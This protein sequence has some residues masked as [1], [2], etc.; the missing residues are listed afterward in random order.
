MKVILAQ[1]NPDEKYK[2]TRHNVG[3]IVLDKIVEQHEAK[4]T[5]Q[6]KMHA[7]IAVIK[8]ADQKVLLVKPTTYYNDTGL[9]ARAIIDYYKL[10][11][12]DALLVVH[13][14]IAIPFGRVRVRNRGQDGGNNGIKSINSHIGQEY[15]RIRVGTYNEERDTIDDANFVLG[16][17]TK[18]ESDQLEKNIVPSVI[19]L[20]ELFVNEPLEPKSYNLL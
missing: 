14:D 2:K 13:D 5:E 15:T 16:K 9:S 12:S 11:P 8:I 20:I 3:F 7:S 6:P 17:F 1:G 18:A 4:W 19:S 10:D